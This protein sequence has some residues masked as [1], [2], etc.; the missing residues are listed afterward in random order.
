MLRCVVA[1]CA[2]DLSCVGFCTYVLYNI[3]FANVRRVSLQSPNPRILHA[4]RINFWR[5]RFL[6]R[7]SLSTTLLRCPSRPTEASHNHQITGSNRRLDHLIPHSP[8]A[9]L[10]SAKRLHRQIQP[11]QKSPDPDCGQ[12]SIHDVLHS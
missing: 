1:G 6:P 5:E 8:P 12:P 3:M 10:W 11:T 9:H 2:T 7:P 4:A